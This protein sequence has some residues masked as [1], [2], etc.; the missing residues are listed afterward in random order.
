MSAEPAKPLIPDDQLAADTEAGPAVEAAVHAEAAADEKLTLVQRV[1][2]MN[3]AQKVKFAFRADKE[4]RTLLLKESSRLV[5]MAVLNSPKITEQEIESLAKS[6]NVSEE[7]LR[8]IAR[9][10]EWM[11][12]YSIKQ[13]L[14]SNPK[15][16]V[17]IA[18][19]LLAS[20]TTRDLAF[21]AKDK[22]VPEPVRN[23]AMRLSKQ[24]SEREG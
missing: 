23:A 12:K 14:A 7:I 9:R 15:T 18:M 11:A 13:G 6:R 5:L 16:P 19:G 24:R 3:V 1:T 8:A 17:S 20:L 22:G 4:G 21:L 10:R 2:R